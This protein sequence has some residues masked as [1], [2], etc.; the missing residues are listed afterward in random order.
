MKNETKA[1][2]K[3]GHLR[4]IT[5]KLSGALKNNPCAI[6]GVQCDSD[7]GL[8]YYDNQTGQVVCYLCAEKHAPEM[9]MIQKAANDYAERKSTMMLYDLRDNVRN[10]ISE[11]VEE[12]IMKVLDGMCEKA[13]YPF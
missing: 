4:R 9:I 6:C 13:E 7:G 10:A 3:A 1:A 12:R 8:L 2:E 11:P 5:L